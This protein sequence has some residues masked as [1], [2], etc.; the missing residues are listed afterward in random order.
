MKE[1]NMKKII[2]KV[3]TLALVF[4][5]LVAPVKPALAFDF[6]G[7]ANLIEMTTPVLT[8]VFNMFGKDN[9]VEMI[10]KWTPI[11]VGFLKGLGMVADL[12]NQNSTNS[13]ITANAF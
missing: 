6:G 5:L 9:A 4:G 1:D 3:F 2:K 12:F 7:T 8:T 11:I 13:V 10:N